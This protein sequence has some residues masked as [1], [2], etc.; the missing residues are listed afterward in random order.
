MGMMSA[1][2]GGGKL[3]KEE[4]K[5]LLPQKP[6]IPGKILDQAKGILEDIVVMA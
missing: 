6:E 5:K 3:T 2:S 1:S 4:I